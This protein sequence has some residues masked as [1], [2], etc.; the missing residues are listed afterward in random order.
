LYSG[1]LVSCKKQE[2]GAVDVTSSGAVIVPC[3]FFC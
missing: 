3:H 2:N 1:F